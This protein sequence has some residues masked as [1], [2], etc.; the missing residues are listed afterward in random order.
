MSVADYG[1]VFAALRAGCSEDW[2]AYTHHSFVAGLCDGTLPRARFV[3][4][5]VQDYVFLVHFA[6]AWSLGVVKAETLDEMKICARTVDALVNHEMALHVKT[7]ASEGID[8]PTLFAA[9]EDV[10]NLAYTRYVMDAGLQGDFLDLIA[11]LAPCCFGYGEI[12]LRLADEATVD[13]PYADWIKTYAD[14]DYQQVMVGIGQMFDAAV[15][16][17]LGADFTATPRWATLQRRFATAT[18]LEAGFWDMGLRTA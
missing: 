16:R 18:Q 9:K 11:A 8:E 15:I 3:K 14:A 7:C 1:R 4:Y 10:T 13:T 2:A 5:L 6:R 17:R 12:G